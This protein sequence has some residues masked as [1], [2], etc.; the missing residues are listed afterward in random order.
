MHRNSELMF[1]RYARDRIRDG[2]RVLEIGPD[3]LP[4]TYQQAV[5]CQPAAWETM[6]FAVR[7]GLTHTLV[8]PYSFPLA[9]D[10]FDVVL[11]CQ[12]IEHVPKIWRW[13]PELVRVVRPGGLVITVAPVSWPYHEA[14]VDCWRMYPDGLSALY[15]DSG[16]VVEL[17][18]WGSPE[19]EHAL[20]RMPRR[21]QERKVSQ[22]LSTAILLLHKGARLPLQGAFDTVVVGRKPAAD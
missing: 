18:E 5:M 14:P 15:E 22:Y 7:D 1:E 3:Q 21:L 8:D 19:M 2:D 12:V 20:R 9:D 10:S 4:S 16:L 11:S 13:M 17:A 6:D